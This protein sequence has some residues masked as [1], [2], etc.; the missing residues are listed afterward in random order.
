M[1]LALKF[2][3]CF[4]AKNKEKEC[5]VKEVMLSGPVGK[6]QVAVYVSL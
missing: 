3:M 2:A 5:Q 1:A 4:Q 6:T